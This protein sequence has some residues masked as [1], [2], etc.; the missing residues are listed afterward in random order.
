[1]L[2]F[3]YVYIIIYFKKNLNVLQIYLY[4]IKIYFLLDSDR[5]FIGFDNIHILFIIPFQNIFTH[6][7]QIEPIFIDFKLNYYS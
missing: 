2:I 6:S 3:R 1:M 7:G 5:F 4:N